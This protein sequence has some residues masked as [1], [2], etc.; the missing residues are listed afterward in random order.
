MGSRRRPG[1]QTRSLRAELGVG[2]TETGSAGICITKRAINKVLRA[3]TKERFVLSS[4]LLQPSSSACSLA[5]PLFNPPPPPSTPTATH[6]NVARRALPP[7]RSGVKGAANEDIYREVAPIALASPR[8]NK[9]G[10]VRNPR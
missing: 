6:T 2:K 3:P 9:S 8:L 7:M 5:L 10:F 4:S 1:R